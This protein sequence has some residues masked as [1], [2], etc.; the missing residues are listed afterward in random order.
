M[1][2]AW[3]FTPKMVFRAGYGMFYLPGSGGI[4]SGVSDLGAGLPASTS[5]FRQRRPRRIRRRRGASIA[6]PFT[7]GIIE[8]PS[9]NVGSGVTTAFRDWVTPDSQ[10]WNANFQ[11]TLTKRAIPVSR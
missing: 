7:T 8:P 11:R 9:T 5:V 10:Q 4:G 3:Q 1:G 6:N 2:L